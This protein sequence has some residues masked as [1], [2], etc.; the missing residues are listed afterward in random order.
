MGRKGHLVPGVDE[1]NSRCSLVTNLLETLDSSTLIF[2][3]YI[4]STEKE[5]KG[6]LECYLNLSQTCPW[7]PGSFNI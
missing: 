5:I 2:Y 6:D 1:L 3:D 7:L 4:H